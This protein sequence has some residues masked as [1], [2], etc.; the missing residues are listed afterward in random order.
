MNLNVRNRIGST[1]GLEEIKNH[2][3]Y[4]NFDWEKLYKK[5]LKSF[6]QMDLIEE[7]IPNKF[8]KI[9]TN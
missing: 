7:K 3:F 1:N 6:I 4:Q 5:E 2:P 8:M 9:K